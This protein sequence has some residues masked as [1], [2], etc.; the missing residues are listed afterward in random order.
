MFSDDIA[1]IKIVIQPNK[2]SV[3]FKTHTEHKS[4]RRANF[5]LEVFFFEN[6]KSWGSPI[7]HYEQK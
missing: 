6:G 2:S 7:F 4:V 1:H 3:V 5:C